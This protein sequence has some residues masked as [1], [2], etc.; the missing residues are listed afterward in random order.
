MPRSPGAVAKDVAGEADVEPIDV[1]GVGPGVVAAD[2]DYND[3]EKKDTHN[4]SE[5]VVETGIS[6]NYNWDEDD[7]DLFLSISTQEIL[8]QNNFS[9]TSKRGHK[10]PANKEIAQGNQRNNKNLVLNDS[11][12]ALGFQKARLGEDENELEKVTNKMHQ[13]EVGKVNNPKN[14]LFT[15]SI[16]LCGKR[17]KIVLF[18]LIYI[19][20]S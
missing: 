16:S 20:S 13:D 19:C 6:E 2:L 7:N 18:V 14:I 15:Y 17:V 3:I 8:D 4:V 11:N 5:G 1:V 12:V 9:S 10:F